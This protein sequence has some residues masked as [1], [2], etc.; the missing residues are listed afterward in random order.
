V[1]TREAVIRA[2]VV[3]VV[4]RDPVTETPAANWPGLAYS[5]AT[6]LELS[7]VS[8]SVRLSTSATALSEVSPPTFSSVGASRVPCVYVA[9]PYQTP[10]LKNWIELPLQL[11]ARCV[12]VSEATVPPFGFRRPVFPPYSRTWKVPL[13]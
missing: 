5:H 4:D 9:D 13:R 6:L 8:N 1:V 12:Q 7:G 10:F 3:Q 11:A 2:L